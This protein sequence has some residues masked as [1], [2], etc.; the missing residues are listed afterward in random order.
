MTADVVAYYASR[1]NAG[2]ADGARVPWLPDISGNARNISQP[3]TSKQFIART[4]HYGSLTTWEANLS[5]YQKQWGITVAEP[6]SILCVVEVTGPMTTDYCIHS[7]YSRPQKHMTGI[8]FDNPARWVM[9][10]EGVGT[11]IYSSVSP[12]SSTLYVLRSD[13]GATDK[14]WVN[15]VERIS[16]NAGN[17]ASI[18]CTIACRENQERHVIGYFSEYA[19]IK[20]Q[21]KVA[22]AY[23]ELLDIFGV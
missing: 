9:E 11:H 22:G 14:L 18:G 10:Q 5:C 7:G 4:N 17:D 1:L 16:G 15:G 8:S 23:A 19:F 2:A 13:Y 3:T 21:A 6:Y 12:V 20:N